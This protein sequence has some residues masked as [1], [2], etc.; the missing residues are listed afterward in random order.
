MPLRFNHLLAVALVL[1]LSAG[2]HVALGASVE[3]GVRLHRCEER[4][5]LVRGVKAIVGSLRRVPLIM[6]RLHPCF[7][8]DLRLPHRCVL[9][10][11][12]LEHG[13]VPEGDAL[14]QHVVHDHGQLG[15]DPLM[16]SK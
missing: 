5:P 14:A 8:G 16:L 1:A 15:V 2:P 12:A 6:D 11:G 9:A 3:L 10:A 13:P 4:L 7:R